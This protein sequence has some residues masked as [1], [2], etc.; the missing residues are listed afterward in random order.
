MDIQLLTRFFM[1]CTILNG[2]LL[3]ITAFICM[4]AGDWA[5]KKQARLFAI[6]TYGRIRPNVLRLFQQRWGERLRASHSRS[7]PLKV[8]FPV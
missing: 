7:F 8:G 5:Y 3:M 4:F 2:G 1:W 6:S